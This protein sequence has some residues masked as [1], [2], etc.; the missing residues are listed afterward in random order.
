VRFGNAGRLRRGQGEIV[1]ADG[2][3]R[4]AEVQAIERLRAQLTR[5]DDDMAARAGLLAG[6]AH[7]FVCR[8]PFGKLL[9]VVQHDDQRAFEAGMEVAEVLPAEPR[10][11]RRLPRVEHRQRRASGGQ[12]RIG[13]AAEIVKKRGHI[14]VP[15]IDLVPEAAQV[16]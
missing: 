4:G 7:Y 8:R 3:E 1:R 15:G 16:P 13:R 6:D 11:V 5:C 14:L 2:R 9:V 12:V 10:Q